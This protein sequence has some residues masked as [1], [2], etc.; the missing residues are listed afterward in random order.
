MSLWF[1]SQRVARTLPHCPQN[2]TIAGEWAMGG[3]RVNAGGFFWAGGSCAL[4][5]R[6]TVPLRLDTMPSPGATRASPS[7]RAAGCRRLQ[8]SH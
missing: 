3:S 7:Y 4:S 5:Y 1:E 8:S 6:S 2:F